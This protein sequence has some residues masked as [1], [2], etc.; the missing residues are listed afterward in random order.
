[1]NE[2]IL[3][4]DGKVINQ[5]CPECL[6]KFPLIAS[7]YKLGRRTKGICGICGSTD[8]WGIKYISPWKERRT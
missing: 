6:K 1:M 7:A 4:L 3:K 2:P 8:S 5:L